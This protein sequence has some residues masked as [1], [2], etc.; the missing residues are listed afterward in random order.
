MIRV[1]LRS[2]VRIFLA[3]C[4]FFILLLSFTSMLISTYLSEM[5]R[6]ELK[7]L[8]IIGNELFAGEE[9]ATLRGVGIADPAYLDW[10]GSFCEEIFDVLKEWKV[11]V[12]RV[13]VHPIFWKR[14]DNYLERYLDKVID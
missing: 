8:R 7:S 6:V 4:I 3:E 13:P 12:V 11:N 5:K 10:E 1:V 9:V 2:L 14:Y